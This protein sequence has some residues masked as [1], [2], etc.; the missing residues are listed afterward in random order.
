MLAS[1]PHSSEDHMPFNVGPLELVIVLVI[2]LLVIGPKRL[3]EMGNSL[4]K[5]IREF[6]KASSDVSDAVSLE[7]EAKPAA[8]QASAS[9]ATPAAAP[10]AP[11][12]EPSPTGTADTEA[13]PPAPSPTEAIPAQAAEATPAEPK[14]DDT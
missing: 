8:Q 4:G 11:A 3:P 6:R 12:A 14:S 7:P 13:A 9:T 2:A 10:V 5:T 1:D